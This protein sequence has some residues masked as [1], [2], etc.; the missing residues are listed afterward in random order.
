M[1]HDLL[2]RIIIVLD[3][4]KNVV[5]IA[6][7]TRVMQNFGL[8]TLRLVNPEEFNAYR[9]EGIAH[10]STDLV[11]ATTIHTTLQDAVGD[12]SF[13]VGTTGRPRT[14]GRTYIR[15]REAGT[16]L[17]ERAATGKVV[18]ILGREDRGLT[19]EALDL[20]HA[21]MIIPTDSEHPSL[22]LAQAC[23]VAAYEI[24]L[25]V[26]GGKDTLPQGRR[27]SRPPTQAELEETYAALETGLHRIE[28]FKAREPSAVLRTIRTIVSRATPDLREARLLAAIGYEIDHYI[29]RN[30]LL[31]A[32]LQ[33]LTLTDPLTGLPNRRHLEVYLEREIE[34][35]QRGRKLVLAMF[36]LDNFK[37]CNDTF[38]HVVGDKV[39]MT[40]GQILNA[41]NR[42]MNIVARY[43]GDEFVAVLSETDITGAELYVQRVTERMASNTQLLEYGITVSV[44][45]AEFDQTSAASMESLIQAADMDMYSAKEA[46]RP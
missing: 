37:G 20:C 31:Q 27:A 10:R 32:D 41:E 29:N 15:P 39:L 11:N 35:A 23:L 26:D 33:A 3:H 13:I 25:A 1:S 6:G 46:S 5:N 16:L 42:A 19:N 28:F 18:I 8:K 36:D 9:I 17:A 40:L 2:S 34:A 14:A 45:L 30:E 21:V 24:F 38:G 44:G 4:P 43:G 12:A 7:V 22:N